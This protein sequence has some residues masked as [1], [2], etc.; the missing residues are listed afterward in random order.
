MSLRKH[1]DFRVMKKL[2]AIV[3]FL[4]VLN[5]CNNDKWAEYSEPDF[6]GNSEAVYLEQVDSA[7][8]AVPEKHYNIFQLKP[9]VVR[10]YIDINRHKVLP[11]SLQL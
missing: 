9:S 7:V 3:I 1:N 4:S 11:F 2:A 8:I 10:A 5:S 6:S